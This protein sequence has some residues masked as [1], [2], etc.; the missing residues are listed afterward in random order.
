M[1]ASLMAAFLLCGGG[2]RM[3]WLLKQFG[4][5]K[6]DYGFAC[7]RHWLQIDGKVVA[8]TEGDDVYL[9]DG[10][11]VRLVQ[12]TIDASEWG[13]LNDREGKGDKRRTV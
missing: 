5:Y 1:M 4:Y 11:I 13:D 8:Q 7:G 12:G 2:Y 10:D 6:F 3:R 9:R